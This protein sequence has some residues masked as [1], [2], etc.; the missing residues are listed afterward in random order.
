MFLFFLLLFGKKYEHRKTS[1]HYTKKKRT[2]TD[3]NLFLILFM[4]ETHSKRCVE[5]FSSFFLKPK[6]NVD[7]PT[8]NHLKKWAV[9]KYFT[10]KITTDYL[11]LY[12]SILSLSNFYIDSNSQV[13]AG[14]KDCDSAR[15]GMD[16]G[17]RQLADGTWI[18]ICTHDLS[19]QRPDG[20]CPR[21]VGE[22]YFPNSYLSLS[23][24]HSD[25]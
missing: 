2:L 21:V 23:I 24:T 17:C 4:V 25:A 12:N 14:A 3:R 11:L 19:P 10:K 13:G 9:F 18:C 22:F 20:F 5:G 1:L 8:Q 7:T 6:K 15:C 16:A